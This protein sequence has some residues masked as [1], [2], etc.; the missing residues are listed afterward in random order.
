VPLVD[1]FGTGRVL[2]AHSYDI[3]DFGPP[4]ADLSYNATFVLLTQDFTLREMPIQNSTGIV[5]H[6]AGSYGLVNIPT[7]NTGI[8]VITY[9][10][11]PTEGG[12]ILMP[13][14][15]SALA[16]EVTFGASMSGKEW[17]ATDT[18]EVT[19][20]NIAYQATLAL[21][22]LQGYEVKG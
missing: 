5:K 22:S 17:V 20:N 1:D 14:G 19:V 2:L 9:S 11:S 6:P 13:W 15:I 4:D 8:L 12:I 3:T 21:W 10:K 16:F 7:N 18:R